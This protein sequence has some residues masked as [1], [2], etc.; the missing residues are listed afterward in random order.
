LNRL[1][2]KSSDSQPERRGH[3]KQPPLKLFKLMQYNNLFAARQLLTH[4][5]AAASAFIAGAPRI[6]PKILVSLTP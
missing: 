2:R 6:R 5:P 3:L 4:A 1:Y